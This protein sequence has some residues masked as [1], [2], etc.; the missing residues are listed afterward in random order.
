MGV[1]KTSRHAADDEHRQFFWQNSLAV[2]ELLGELLQVHPT[3]ELH[4]D[5]ENAA[6]FSKMIGL[7]DVGV[8]E[9][10]DKLC[11][12]NEVIDELPL[13]GVILPDDLDGDAFEEIVGAELLSLI[14][15][16]HS[17]LKDL[18]YDLV[19]KFILYGKK[20]HDADSDKTRGQV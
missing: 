7:N 16:T 13:V 5:E 4:G 20:R 10:G 8:N 14:D 15:N 9:I 19:A 12:P 6:G 1:S 11:F 18:A 3:D 17:A 2:E